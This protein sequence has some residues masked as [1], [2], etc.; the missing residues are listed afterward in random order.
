MAV[1]TTPE[2]MRVLGFGVLF[3]LGMLLLDAIRAVEGVAKWPNLFATAVS[4][5]FVGMLFVFGWRV[6]HGG[7]AVLFFGVLV[8]ALGTGFILRR[9]RKRA[10]IAS[11][12]R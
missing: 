11:K 1:G 4:S 6:L 3:G 12:M 2:W 10:E 7:I 9:A 5:F 8:A